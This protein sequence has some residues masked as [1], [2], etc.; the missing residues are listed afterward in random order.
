MDIMKNF[1]KP[2]PAGE[3]AAVDES[4]LWLQLRVRK[5]SEWEA[6]L[7]GLIRVMEAS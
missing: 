6:P 7:R 1:I 3:E 2:L 5:G 4:L